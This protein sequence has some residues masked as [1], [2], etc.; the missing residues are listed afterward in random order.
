MA[1]QYKNKVVY[2]DQT[3]MDITDTTAEQADV[4]EGQVF[5]R[6]NGARSVGT[7]TDATQSTHGLMSTADKIKLDGIVAGAGVVDVQIDSTSVVNNAGIADLPYASTTAAG[8][9]SAADK[10]IIDVFRSLRLSVDA[11]GYVCQT[12][13]VS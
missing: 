6:A 2:G 9:L 13:E 8:L 4:I 1:N 12:V 11:Q 3:L 7:L 10:T 5:Y